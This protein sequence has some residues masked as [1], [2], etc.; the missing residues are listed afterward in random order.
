M[1][2]GGGTQKGIDSSLIGGEKVVFSANALGPSSEVACRLHY[3]SFWPMAFV[4]VN[5]DDD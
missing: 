3:A 2:R 1:L 5:I 4:P